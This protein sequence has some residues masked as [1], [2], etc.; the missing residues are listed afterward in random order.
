ME[1]SLFETLIK[2]IVSLPDQVV[3]EEHRDDKGKLFIIR[4]HKDDMSTI[5][6]SKG[7]NIKAIRLFIKLY[8]KDTSILVKEP[9]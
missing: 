7:N 4:V 2:G 5:I 9:E 1:K 8:S 3:I 6:G